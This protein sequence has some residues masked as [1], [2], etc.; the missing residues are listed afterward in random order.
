MLYLFI[1]VQ[2]SAAETKPVI[3]VLATGGT[4]AG[5]GATETTTIGYRAAVFTVDHLLAAVP[6]LKNPGDV[7][8]EQLF[9]IASENITPDHW[10]K[11]ARRVNALLSDKNISG[12][13][14]THG[15]DT[16]EETAYFL[17]LTVKSDKPVVLVG[18]M[19]PATAISADGPINLYNA[20]ALAASPAARGKGVLV[21]L[22]DR[23]SSAREVTKPNTFTAD[24]FRTPD[25]GD[26]GYM[27]LGRPFFYRLPT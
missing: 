7:R 22:N 17:H 27:Q 15:T 14:I 13:V 21:T 10:L 4:I 2:L 12:V 26:L 24:T 25:I 1:T 11:M 5:S 3:A 23:S 18:S 16:L 19:R 20:V 9:Q 6:S 8:G